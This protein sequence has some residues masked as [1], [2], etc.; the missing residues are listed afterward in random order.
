MFL[1]IL[2]LQSH[3]HISERL[4]NGLS[5]NENKEQGC[6]LPCGH[7]H[8]VPAPALA[9][10]LARLGFTDR[11]LAFP[12][13][14][15][16]SLGLSAFRSVTK[17][18]SKHSPHSYCLCMQKIKQLKGCREGSHKGISQQ[19]W[20]RSVSC[21]LFIKV[22]RQDKNVGHLCDIIRSSNIKKTCC[23]RRTHQLQEMFSFQLSCKGNKM[24]R[25]QSW[26]LSQV[27]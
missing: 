25:K 6:F 24:R 22:R 23:N 1:A 11:V 9:P 2:L 17:T 12:V 26:L 20:S 10:P 15:R 21:L 19:E 3:F 4:Q 16:K 13:F 14:P 7:A 8:E 5:G 18:V 27:K